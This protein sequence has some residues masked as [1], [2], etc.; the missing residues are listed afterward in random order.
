[1]KNQIIMLNTVT[2]T[3]MNSF[4]ITTEDDKIFVMDGGFKEDLE[5]LLDWLRK[6]TGEEVPHI[7]GWFMSHPHC[8]H[9]SAFNRLMRD[10]PDAVKV[11]AVY[12]NFPSSQYLNREEPHEM[13]NIIF[14]ENIQAFPAKK[15]VM[16]ARDEYDCGAAKFEVLC[17]PSPEFTSNVY[18]NAS[19]VIKMTLGG[20][21]AIFL[22][23][24]GVEEGQKLLRMYAG[25]DKL[26][27]DYV[28]M[29]HHGQNGV[30]RDVYEAIAPTGCLWCT[31]R[32]LWNNDAGKGYNTCFWKT[33]IVQGWMRELGVKEHYIMMNGVQ[34]VEL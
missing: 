19:C 13:S 33:I 27:A 16:F 25:T 14:E 28:Q 7:D 26:K 17:S 32:W 30:D 22:G 8:D 18:N 21:S 2:G 3:Q 5:N 15:V 10:C 29:A 9:I 23:D 31:P 20:K 34:T 4:I 1:M 11:D 12:Y 24:A 6:L